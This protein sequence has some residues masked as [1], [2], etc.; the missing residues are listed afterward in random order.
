MAAGVSLHIKVHMLTITDHD[1]LEDEYVPGHFKNL[2][3][4]TN[5]VLQEDM[6]KTTSG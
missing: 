5:A 3:T 4:C 2:D 1:A 6:K